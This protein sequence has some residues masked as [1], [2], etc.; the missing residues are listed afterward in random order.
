MSDNFSSSQYSETPAN[1]TEN[2]VYEA[3]K[4]YKENKFDGEVV[5]LGDEVDLAKAVEIGKKY[6]SL[7]DYSVSD[8]VNARDD[9]NDRDSYHLWDWE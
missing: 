5:E 4:I 1:P 6:G 9:S 8:V 7:L 3:L 2:A